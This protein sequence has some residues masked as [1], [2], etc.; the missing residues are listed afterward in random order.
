MTDI[1]VL[2]QS[3][4]GQSAEVVALGTRLDGAAPPT[5]MRVSVILPTMNEAENVEA[6]CQRLSSVRENYRHL[7][8]AIFVLNNTTDGTDKILEE[9][10]KKPGYDFLKVAYS[11]GARGSAI[12]K[13]VEIAQEGIVVVMD[14]DGQY[15]TAEIPKL[16]RPI[17]DE[18]YSI[19][20]ARNHG[21]AN[22]SRRI[23]SESFKKLTLAFLGVRYVQTG[24]KAGLKSALLDTVPRDVSGL[25]IDVRWMDN[26][27]RKGYS[28]KL[29][30]DV[31]VKLHPRLHGKTTFN[32]LK[33]SLG[34]LYTTLSLAV[35]RRTG[36]ELPFLRVLGEITLQPGRAHK[37]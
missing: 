36:R 28:S 16:V 22:L 19:V 17:V 30:H 33:L 3:L 4:E 21:W 6:L 8:E 9:L 13:G 27:V 20:V 7:V 31:E 35:R 2:G 29:S 23:T 12:R 37:A 24:F 1:H 11:K 34:L 18:D 25:D 15:D 14:S 26:V 5:V 32:L 10:S